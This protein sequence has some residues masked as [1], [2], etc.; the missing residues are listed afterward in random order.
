MLDQ[1]G[2]S[3]METEGKMIEQFSEKSTAS[4]GQR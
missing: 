4:T 1:F 3:R 2:L